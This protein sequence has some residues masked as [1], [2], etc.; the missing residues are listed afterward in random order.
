MRRQRGTVI[1]PS[2]RRRNWAIKY[3]DQWGN[4]VWEGGFENRGKAQSRLNEVLKDV[5]VGAYI[6]RTSATF[7]QFAKEW[8]EG[9]LRVRGST[10][11]GYGS[12]IKQQ[13]V[14]R[15]GRLRVS[16]IQLEHTQKLINEMAAAGRSS[17]TIH[18]TATLLR[19]MLVG[20]R[21]SA[22]HR[23]LIGQDPCAA[24]ELPELVKGEV[25]PPTPKQVWHLIEVARGISV[26]EHGMTFLG[27]HTGVRRN[28]LLALRFDDI[29]WFAKQLR[30]RRAISKAKG[31]DGAHKWQWILHEPKSKR[32]R[33]R[34][35][36][37][38]SALKVLS[39]LKRTG[40]EHGFIFETADGSWID[41]DK[42][43]AEIW[44]PIVKAAK[45][46]G[47]RFH[48]LRHFFASQLIAQGESAA[49]V[50]DQ[51]GHGSIQVTF[52]TYGHLFPTACHEATARLEKSMAAA[53][54]KKSSGSTVVA[55]AKSEDLKGELSN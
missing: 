4:Q 1:R 46:E 24:L 38:E 3:R 22:K 20:K 14:P 42:F 40:D 12:I 36:L 26:R 17:K 29:D 41:P 15:L 53:R 2:G 9:R 50:R 23:G 30:I 55:Q 8:L 28:E 18:N 16:D 5:D 19:T 45:L 39:G 51:M 25:I 49:Y 6:P 48:D 13:L 31:D 21:G 54:E 37:T 35:N 27:A 44:A 11:S 7:E 32:S 34:I 10:T 52:D 47:T 33:R 43:D